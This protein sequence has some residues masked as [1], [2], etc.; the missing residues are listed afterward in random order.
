[1]PISAA[2]AR[3]AQ[4][5]YAQRTGGIAPE[6]RE[7]RLGARFPLHPGALAFRR[8]A[9]AFVGTLLALS[10]VHCSVGNSPG[11]AG[12][13]IPHAGGGLRRTADG[14]VLPSP[15]PAA[16]C[17]SALSGV[18]NAAVMVCAVRPTACLAALGTTA[19][20][21]GAG[22]VNA[23]R[24]LLASNQYPATGEAA[25]EPAMTDPERSDALS[26]GVV[27]TQVDGAPLESRLL[28]IARECGGDRQ[29]RADGIRALLEQL[30]PSAQIHLQER[31]GAGRSLIS[32]SVLP[33]VGAAVL[34]D[35]L[36]VM[37]QLVQLL[38]DLYTPQVAAYQDDLEEI[39]SAGM[40]SAVELRV[41]ARR[42]ETIE[43]LLQRDG[44]T[45]Q[46]QPYPTEG[47]QAR[48]R[49]LPPQMDNLHAV[50]RA[51]TG[52]RL[53]FVAHGDMIGQGSQGAYDNASGVAALLHVARQLG[54]DPGDGTGSVEV[55]VTSCEELGLLGSRAHVQ[56]CQQNRT[57]P[58]MVIN[59][60][61]VGRGGHGYIL[62]DTASVAAYNNLGQPPYHL[63][64]AVTSSAEVRAE[65]LVRN[66]FSDH[67]FTRH[68]ADIP[69]MITSDNLSFQNQSIP[70]VG[71]MQMDAPGAEALRAI[72]QARA[73]WVDASKAIDWDW[74]DLIDSGKA[75]ATAE[76]RDLMSARFRTLEAAEFRYRQSYVEERDAPLRLIHNDRDHLA[77]VNP[78]M[79][80][81]FADVLADVAR[82]WG[83]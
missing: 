50:I 45:V 17:A 71:L 3:S 64:A 67:G 37:D 49:T 38:A 16:S 31:I 54:A 57:C 10:F 77:R 80:V 62:S 56:Q 24:H 18:A 75:Q 52:T 47:L 81:A 6:S 33:G 15:P 76:E 34:P 58:D 26:A 4:C 23:G 2:D 28:A 51:G 65:A 72:D 42:L 12:M 69:Y 32:S 5:R 9:D 29:C 60:D 83:R 14:D 68:L 73:A 36:Q 30:P 27:A 61:M 40:K 25:A 7:A 1:M 8:P 41:N 46:R 66:V 79:A 55:L 21:A 74:V 35:M 13:N 22:L 19:I 63:G 59:V 70:C 39:V 11:V 20:F 82:A 78:Q 48:G 53:L 44:F 43:Q